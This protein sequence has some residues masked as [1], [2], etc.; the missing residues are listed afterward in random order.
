MAANSEK[1]T[2]KAWAVRMSYALKKDFRVL[3]LNGFLHDVYYLYSNKRVYAKPDF[4]GVGCFKWALYSIKYALGKGE[5]VELEESY[6]YKLGRENVDLGTFEYRFDAKEKG[7]GWKLEG[8]FCFLSLLFTLC[9]VLTGLLRKY[10]SGLQ[11]KMGQFMFDG[12]GETFMA[13]AKA[14]K[15]LLWMDGMLKVLF[16]ALIAVTILSIFFGKRFSSYLVNIAFP[17]FL[18]TD[19]KELYRQFADQFPVLV[20][21]RKVL[22]FIV[23]VALLAFIIYTIASFNGMNVI[24]LITAAVLF[25]NVK[26]FAVLAL[27]IYYFLKKGNGGITFV[28]KEAKASKLASSRG[29]TTASGR[30]GIYEAPRRAESSVSTSLY[31]SSSGSST[32]TYD[33]E[34]ESLK[35]E[36][37]NLVGEN[38]RYEREIKAELAHP[39]KWAD[40]RAIES[41]VDRL[42]NYITINNRNIEEK[43]KKIEKLKKL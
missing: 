27:I 23:V 24:M 42:K 13:E 7:F 31:G 32:G 34:I 1:A 38:E 20:S 28:F 33:R 3:N 19:N 30:Q 25:S 26:F 21:A 18:L 10:Q 39:N 16:I 14:A 15:T 40:E 9:L 2:Y 29:S 5:P 6:S 8:I 37:E 17:L 22:T 35:K 11:R 12:Y 41:K 4:L 43:K 36:I